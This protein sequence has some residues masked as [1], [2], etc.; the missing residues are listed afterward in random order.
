MGAQTRSSATNSPVKSQSSSKLAVSHVEGPPSKLFILPK[1]ASAEAR[2][3]LLDH[4]Q[5]GVKRRFYFCPVLGLCEFKRVCSSTVDPRSVLFTECG[6]NSLGDDQRGVGASSTSQETGK[7]SNGNK[8]S[9]SSSRVA[10]GYVNKAAEVFVATPFDVVFILIALL[11]SQ[12]TSAKSHSGKALFQ[13]LDDLLEAHLDGDKHLRYIFERGRALLESAASTICDFVDSGDEKMYRIND[14]KL[15]HM[16]LAKAQRSVAHGLPASLE[17]RF[18]KRA[19]EKPVLSIKREET[20]ISTTTEVSTADSSGSSFG[21]NSS[22]TGTI[23]SAASTVA[24]EVSSTTTITG[25]EEEVIPD[26]ILQLQ[27]LRTVWSFITSSYLPHQ[28]AEAMTELLSSKQW[29]IHFAPLDAYLSELTNLRTEALASRN[30]SNFSLKRGLE[31][32]DTAEVR[33]EKKQKQEED[34]KR[35]KAG[36]SRGVRDLKKV[37]VTGMKKMSSF[38]IKVPA[39]KA[40]T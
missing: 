20:T 12:G 15:F 1:D 22:Q 3:L 34:E 16:I 38:F 19:L 18:V 37:N 11:G 29:A 35:K 25:N 4:P 31:D 33:A 17:E 32:D 13:P 2:F 26:T 9:P 7:L 23:V 21:S 30:V 14:A 6:D 5:D 24:S 40:K 36:E 27:R 39:A 8:S 10:G 28:T